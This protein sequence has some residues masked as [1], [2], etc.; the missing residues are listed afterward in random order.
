MLQVLLPLLLLSASSIAAPSLQSV[1]SVQSVQTTAQST[2][3]Q[4]ASDLYYTPITSVTD[5]TRYTTKNPDVELVALNKVK[6]S[7]GNLV[8][9]SGQRISG[10]KL[11]VNNYA[12]ESFTTA[13]NVEVEMRYPSA[14][15]TGS[16]L[17]C[18]EI[19]VDSS[20]NDADA[21]FTEGSIG[22]TAAAILLTSDQTRTFSYEAYFY[23]Y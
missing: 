18:I 15:G 10:D 6:H 7:K 20:A 23:G 14:T 19:Y 13:V 21:Y 8:F 2:A 11:L 1:Q 12:D 16:T 4:R 9:S 22:K 17:T 5:E 3:Q